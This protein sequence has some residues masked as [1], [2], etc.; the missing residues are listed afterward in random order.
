MFV[1]KIELKWKEGQM[2]MGLPAKPCL[3]HVVHWRNSS[4]QEKHYGLE[5]GYIGA[6]GWLLWEGGT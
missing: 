2:D 3:C 5:A 1:S 6:G 4:S